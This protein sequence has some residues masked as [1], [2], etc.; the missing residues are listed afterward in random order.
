MT[1]APIVRPMTRSSSLGCAMICS[2]SEGRAAGLSAIASAAAAK[3][4][5]SRI[6]DRPRQLAALPVGQ[7]AE[8]EATERPGEE[9]DGEDRQRPQDIDAR[10][11]TREEL[12]GEERSEGGVDVPVEPLHRVAGA[13]ADDRLPPA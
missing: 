11:V 3:V 2:H 4:S 5:V 10:V 1:V 13:D 6:R 9:A 8:Q 7:P 12:R